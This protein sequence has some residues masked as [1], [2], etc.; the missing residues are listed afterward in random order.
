[1]ESW[2][3]Q[4]GRN[5]PQRATP[6]EG[7][8]GRPAGA[9]RGDRRA[10]SGPTHNRSLVAGRGAGR[11]QGPLIPRQEQASFLPY[12]LRADGKID[13]GRQRDASPDSDWSIFGNGSTLHSCISVPPA[14][15]ASAPVNKSKEPCFGAA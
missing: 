5:L 15:P 13:L 14:Q 6:R 7:S 4:R 2:R 11:S 8:L 1:M 9:A 12:H 10:H 3:G